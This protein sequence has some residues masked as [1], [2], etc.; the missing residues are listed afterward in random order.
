MVSQDVRPQ[1]G[2]LTR[3]TSSPRPHRRAFLGT[4]AALVFAVA[5]GFSAPRAEAQALPTG[6]VI[7]SVN[8][9]NIRIVDNVLRADGTVAGTL[10]GL[11][12]TTQLTNFALQ[13]VPD[14]AT[15][16]GTECSVLDLALAPIHLKVLGL[17]VDTSAICLEITATQGGGLLGDL[18]CGLAGGGLL[19]TGLPVLPTAAELTNLQGGL[20]NLIGRSLAQLQPGGEDEDSVC[21]GDCH[22]LELS[23]GP[24]D[25]SL[26][27]LNVALDDCD[28]GPVQVCVSATA[29]EGLLGGLLCGLADG[30]LLGNLG[31]IQ[32]LVDAINDALGNVNLTAKQAT[33]LANRLVG[34]LS[35]RLQDGALSGKDLDKVTKTIRQAI[36]K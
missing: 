3:V 24:V 7:N 16:P 11:P 2:Q 9:T 5:L 22:V 33:Q 4:T 36:K 20:V 29:A 12:F 32:Q 17:H 28:N 10:A 25:L 23:L 31:V 18:L 26:L 14:D 34:Q 6:L 27:G 1:G 35:G 15:P 8:L 19:G 30:G 21:T 13:L